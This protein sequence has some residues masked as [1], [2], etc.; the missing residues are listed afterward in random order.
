MTQA[1]QLRCNICGLALS[2]SEANIH[3]STTSHA[4]L[5]RKLEQELET[6]RKGHYANDR[7]VILQWENSI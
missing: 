4:A 1:E 2:S 7:S 5:K 3:A 6:V